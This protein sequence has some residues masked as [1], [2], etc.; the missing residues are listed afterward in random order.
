MDWRVD[1]LTS[2]CIIVFDK[3]KNRPVLISVFA[4]KPS[5]LLT[6]DRADFHN[7][8]RTQFYDIDIR[9]PGKWLME[10]R[11]TDKL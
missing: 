3:A 6:L 5:L 11:D 1:A 8:L 7:R 9:T 4:V 10:M 2:A